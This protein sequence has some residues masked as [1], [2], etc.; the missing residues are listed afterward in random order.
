MGSWLLPRP[1]R[2]AVFAIYRFARH[3]DDIADEGTDPAEARE[4]RLQALHAALREAEAHLAGAQVPVPA[5]PIVAG[6]VEPARLHR[7]GWRPFHDL[8]D[9][10][11]QDLRVRRYAD[12]KS[13]D[14]YCALS[15]NPVG[16]LMLA[17]FGADSAANQASS[18][19]I[20]SALQRINFLQDVA[21]DRSKDRIY[22]PLETLAAV[23]VTGARWFDEIDAGRLSPPSR[24]AVALESA[25]AR[26]QLL[27]GA[28]L[29]TAVPRR[30]GWELRF[31]IAGGVRIL[32]RLQACGHDPVSNRPVLGWRDAGA[33]IAGAVRLQPQVDPSAAGGAR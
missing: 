10:F 1:L 29:I 6:L 9:A 33:L 18:D 11:L 3:A 15:A 26:R 8:L 25:R 14:A 20:C 32:D 17:L 23:G 5:D 30:L 7:L 21:I 13:V 19:S 27:S 28:G 12:P 22:L 31:I 16:R 24:Q 4:A 2:P